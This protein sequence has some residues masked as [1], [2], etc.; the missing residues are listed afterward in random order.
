MELTHGCTE[1][2]EKKEE[3]ERDRQTDNETEKGGGGGKGGG[4]YVGSVSDGEPW[5]RKPVLATQT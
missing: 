1:T 5:I 4:E 3:T 2:E